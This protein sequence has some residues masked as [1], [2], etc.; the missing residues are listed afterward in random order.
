MGYIAGIRANNPTPTT[1]SVTNYGV[2]NPTNHNIHFWGTS[3]NQY[4][5]VIVDYAMVITESASVFANS[6]GDT[7]GNNNSHI[8]LHSQGLM[9]FD[10][11]NSKII[12]D[13]GGNFDFGVA[14]PLD[15][16]I[17]G[18]NGKNRLKVGFDRLATR[19]SLYKLTQ[20]GI[21]LLPLSMRQIA[22]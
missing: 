22:R 4:Y 16:L 13:F 12:L 21:V 6:K 2:I 5:F 9:R 19:S 20:S 11:P 10:N 17:I 14:Y 15:K 7:S 1:M 3:S 18:S 8:V